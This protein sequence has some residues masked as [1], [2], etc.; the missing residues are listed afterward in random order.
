[1]NERREDRKLDM[2]GRKVLCVWLMKLGLR[3]VWWGEVGC[4]T[5]V[6]TKERQNFCIFAFEI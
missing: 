6:M 5:C 2:V 4:G 1:M 3:S